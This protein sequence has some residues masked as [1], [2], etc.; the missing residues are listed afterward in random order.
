MNPDAQ[1]RARRSEV[2]RLWR[3]GL[4]APEIAKRL[5]ASRA[6]VSMDIHHLR[7]S[8]VDLPRRK[9]HPVDARVKAR[10]ER[11][12][13]LWRQGLTSS[14]ITEATGFP[15]AKVL[16]DLRWLRVRGDI[17][18]HDPY[19]HPDRVARRATVG[20]LWE[21]GHKADEIAAK[22]GVRRSTLYKDLE[23]LREEGRDLDFRIPALRG[24]RCQKGRS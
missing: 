19:D 5:G 7:Q 8:G 2:A 6:T 15:Q 10:R 3:E 23:R 16:T 18:A 14:E 24:N 13:T 22:L 12:A 20:D 17:P 11:V 9:S 21:A 4:T 1:V